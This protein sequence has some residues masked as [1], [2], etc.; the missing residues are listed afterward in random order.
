MLKNILLTLASIA[1]TL[2][3]LEAGLR[4]ALPFISN[5]PD[6]FQAER[7]LYSPYRGHELNPLF[8]TR[9]NTDGRKIHSSDGFRRDTPVSKTKPPKTIRIFAM[10]ASTLYGLGTWGGVY[11]NHRDLFNDELTTAYLENALNQRLAQEGSEWHVEVINTAVIAYH[12]FQQLVYLNEK[13]LSYSP[14]IVINIEGHNDFYIAD[15]NYEPWQ[16]Y[17]YS[18]AALMEV[19]NE[20]DFF[21]ALHF[22]VRALAAHSALAAQVEKRITRPLFDARLNQLRTFKLDVDESNLV[23]DFPKTA[24]KTFIRTL[25]QINRLGELEDFKHIVYLQPEIVLENGDDLSPSD[26]NIRKI[27]V[28]NLTHSPV[29]MQR[30]HAMLPELFHQYGIPFQDV[31]RLGTPGTHENLYLDYCHLTP[32]GSQR[33]ARNI[34]PTLLKALHERIAAREHKAIQ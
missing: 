17:P 31:S 29:F 5:Q 7:H 28:D 24:R 26:R 8:N 23:Q 1:V 34:Y 3:L 18:S 13:L 27:T 10:G 14:D 12:T 15:P 19:I 11:P 25:W 20:R 6:P 22:T 4:V 32:E 30:I 16:M 2:F 9:N 21:T 33:L